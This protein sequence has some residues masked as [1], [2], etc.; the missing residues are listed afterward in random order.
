MYR[1]DT[2]FSDTYVGKENILNEQR[3]CS[4]KLECIKI[5]NGVILPHFPKETMTYGLGGVIDSDG[6]FVTESAF[7]LCMNSEEKIDWGGAYFVNKEDFLDRDETIIFGGFINNNEWGHFLVD[8]SIRLWYAL[9]EKNCKIIF[10]ARGKHQID[11]LPNIAQVIELAGIDL[12]RIEILCEGKKPLRFKEII[13]PEGSLTYKGYSS[14]Y[15]SFFEEVKKNAEMYGYEKY[16]KI[17]FTRTKLRPHKEFGEFEIENFFRENG[18]KIMAPEALT[19]KEQIFYV[20]NCKCLASIEGSAAH[21]IIFAHSGVKQVILEKTNIINIRQ[22][23]LSEIAE[24]DVVFVKAYPK[25]RFTSYDTGGPFII[26]FTQLFV[27]WAKEQGVICRN[28]SK[29]WIRNYLIYGFVHIRKK[30]CFY[31]QCILK[32]LERG[33]SN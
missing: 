1:F 31:T 7:S 14:E 11:I 4:E 20:M 19:A 8:W 18:F 2:R 6:N 32:C 10:C 21:N 23:F 30:F 9:E 12:K 25:M 17:Y 16:D 13:I 27:K 33:K 24:A 26:G 15:K 22:L 28:K 3:L 5:Q 29:V